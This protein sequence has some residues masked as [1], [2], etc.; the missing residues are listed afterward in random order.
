MIYLLYHNKNKNQSIL[1][2][3]NYELIDGNFLLTV[4]KV[5]MAGQNRGYMFKFEKNDIVKLN[6]KRD[7]KKQFRFQC[8]VERKYI[9]KY[10]CEYDEGKFEL[11]HLLKNIKTFNEFEQSL[12]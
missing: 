9:E 12:W 1:S 10:M 5:V 11:N 8:S 2:K 3:T 4:T 6:P 7:H